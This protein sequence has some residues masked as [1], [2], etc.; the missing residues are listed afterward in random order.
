MNFLYYLA[1]TILM[2]T[3]S[4]PAKAQTPDDLE[5]GEQKGVASCT[6]NGESLTCVIVE[7]NGNVYSIAGFVKDGEIAPPVERLRDQ[8]ERARRDGPHHHAD[9]ALGP[10][11]PALEPGPVLRSVHRDVEIVGALLDLDLA[12]ERGCR[13][14]VVLGAATEERLF[15]ALELK[16]LASTLTITTDDGSLGE[17]GKVTDVLPEIMERVDAAVV[18]A[19]GPMPMLAS[20]ADIAT[21]LR[22]YSQCAVEEAMACGIGICMTCVLPV[23]GDDGV[24][25]MLRSCVE[26]PVFR[27][28][29]VRWDQVGTI[30]PDT[31]GAPVSGGH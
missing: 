12:R 9:G 10:V 6:V 4:F 22:A 21:R 26:G 25:R 1:A 3:M 19:C 11:L 7:W 17:R 2:L 30:P 24:T 8:H 31:L 28:D 23:V 5:K 18:Y 15:G 27:G 14:D 13:V 16:R 29:R 20:V